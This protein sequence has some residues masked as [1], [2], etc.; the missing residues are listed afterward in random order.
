[1]LLL[2]QQEQQQHREGCRHLE[3]QQARINRLQLKRMSYVIAIRGFSDMSLMLLHR[4][5]DNMHD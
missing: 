4:L 2:L 5:V 3:T 1:M